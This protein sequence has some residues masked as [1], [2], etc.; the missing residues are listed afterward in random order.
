[1]II[2]GKVATDHQMSIA[3]DVELEEQIAEM[4]ALA[5]QVTEVEAEIDKKFKQVESFRN[6]V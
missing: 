6:R 5:Q 4:D 3:L 2:N 1:M